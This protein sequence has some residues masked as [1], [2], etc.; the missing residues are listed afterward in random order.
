MG[1]KVIELE[2]KIHEE[3]KSFE[4]ETGKKVYKISV[5]GDPDTIVVWV[6]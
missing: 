5:C 1:D 4:K 3:V 6:K 2:L